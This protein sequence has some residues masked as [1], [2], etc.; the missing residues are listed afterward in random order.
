MICVFSSYTTNANLRFK[1][2]KYGGRWYFSSE[3]NSFKK[4]KFIKKWDERTKRKRCELGETEVEMKLR[5]GPCICDKMKSRSRMWKVAPPFL[6]ISSL[7]VC[8]PLI[9]NTI[10][11]VW[12]SYIFPPKHSHHHRQLLV[13]KN[14]H[15][16]LE[17]EDLASCT[18]FLNLRLGI[19]SFHYPLSI[20]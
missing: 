3:Q 4:F 1:F 13:K 9:S 19:N 20:F 7:T 10:P 14:Q 8:V 2:N 6:P 5:G 16:Q 11:S 12:A 15:R 17:H 18:Y